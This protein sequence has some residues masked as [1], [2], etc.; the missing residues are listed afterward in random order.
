M[1]LNYDSFSYLWL[2]YM[3]FFSVKEI[4]ASRMEVQTQFNVEEVEINTWEPQTLDGWMAQIK[5][6]KLLLWI[7]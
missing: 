6:K 2:F 1:A 4:G 7:R 3:F 5:A